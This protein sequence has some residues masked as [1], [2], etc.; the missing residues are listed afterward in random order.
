MSIQLRKRE[1]LEQEK[2]LLKT[3][4]VRMAEESDSDIEY[5][6]NELKWFVRKAREKRQQQLGNLIKK[7]KKDE[8]EGKV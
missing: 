4:A 8:A 2:K 5:E 7:K 6:K 3:R 1:Q